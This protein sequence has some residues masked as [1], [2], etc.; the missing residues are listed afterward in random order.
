MKQTKALTIFLNLYAVLFLAGPIIHSLKIIRLSVEVG[1]FTFYISTVIYFFFNL[2]HALSISKQIGKISGYFIDFVLIAIFFVGVLSTFVF[3]GDIVDIAGNFLRITTSV[4]IF[5]NFRVMFRNQRFNNY[6]STIYL[7]RIAKF[8]FFGVCVA[9]VIV[10]LTI[11]SGTGVYLGLS[12]ENVVPFIGQNIHFAPLKMILGIILTV[13]GGKRGVILSVLVGCIYILIFKRQKLK[14]SKIFLSLLFLLLPIFSIGVSVQSDEIFNHLPR[15]IQRRVEPFRL[16]E[17]ASNQLDLAKAT[18]GRNWEVEAV[19]NQWKQE[20]LTAWVGKGF[21]ATFKLEYSDDEDSSV[22][23][24]PIGV[25]FLVGLPLGLLF[26]VT[27]FYYIFKFRS[28]NKDNQVWFFIFLFTVGNS[29]TVFSIF[30]TPIFWI[31]FAA[32]ITKRNEDFN[33]LAKKTL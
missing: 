14:N 22:H 4:L 10:Y 20:P 9:L 16:G 17:I 6:I 24:S 31:S 1:A 21:G 32:L 29:F 25:S 8:G 11:F 2:F 13:L 15:S 5:W 19:F 7:Q 3:Q 26:Y 27:L 12:T 28:P 30:Q 23:I 33:I 18:S